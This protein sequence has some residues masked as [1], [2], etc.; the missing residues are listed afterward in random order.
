MHENNLKGHGKIR[1]GFSQRAE[2]V[3]NR[4]KHN[5]IA[6]IFTEFFICVLERIFCA[7]VRNIKRL[8]LHMP[9]LI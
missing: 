5:L 8:Q 2:V 6:H 9:E 7:F 3:I 1:N 4:R